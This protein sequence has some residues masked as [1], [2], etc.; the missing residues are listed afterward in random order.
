MAKDRDCKN[1]KHYVVT[2]VKHNYELNGCGM[3][4]QKIYGCKK[5]ECEF[6]PKEEVSP[7]TYKD[8]ADAM[9]KM[10]IDNVVTDSEYAK[11]MD[12]LNK[13]EAKTTFCVAPECDKCA[14]SDTEKCP[15]GLKAE[16]EGKE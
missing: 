9:L 10:W 3:Y 4:D 5:R 15:D 6:E 16:S 12:R 1:C 7:I 14:L 11:I 2:D 13:K 8:C